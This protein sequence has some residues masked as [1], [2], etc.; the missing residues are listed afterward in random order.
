LD[1]IRGREV[2]R[3]VGEGTSSQG[4]SPAGL[5]EAAY[6][7]DA[8]FDG[9]G[10][11]D[12]AAIQPNGE[13]VL[14]GNQT[15]TQNRWLTVGLTGVKVTKLALGAE[16]EVKAGPRYQK[17]VYSGIP[18]L[19]GLGTAADVDTVRISWPN[20]LIQNQ[21]KETA[22]RAV[23]YREAPKLAGSCPMVFAWNGREFQFLGDILGVAPLGASSGDGNYFPVDHD[24]YLQI[25]AELLKPRNG[26]YEIRITEEL[27]EVTYLDQVRLIAVDHPERSEIY[28]SEKFKS[29]P[30]AD[31]R[32]YGVERRQYPLRA[33]DGTGRNVLGR[34]IR[35]DRRYIDVPRP[36]LSGVA[37]MHTLDLDFGK[38]AAERNQ[39]IL[40]LNGWTDWADGSVFLNAS[41]R[42]GGS[43]V[44]PYLQVKD[45]GG[46]WRTVI[47]DMGVPSGS[48]R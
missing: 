24:E 35:R 6:W 30:F 7:A 33:T 5:R 32:L 21:T 20:G 38:G 36:D 28:T 17:K 29:P 34:L 47:E 42:P 18:L 31:F 41:Q 23:A 48:P 39:A 8:D 10:R 26:R 19:F 45:A 16:V 27:R 4:S 46:R 40:V 1:L 11:V 13:V 43:L 44:L 37:G 15:K 12:L 3:N 25:P 9:D 2:L 14:L 22:G